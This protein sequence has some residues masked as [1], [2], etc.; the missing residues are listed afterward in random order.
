[1]HDDLRLPRKQTGPHIL[2]YDIETAYALAGVWAQW[3]TNATHIERDWYILCFAYKWL[4]EGTHWVGLPD[5]D[6]YSP[7]AHDDRYVVERLRDLLDYADIVI[8]HNGDSFDQ[9]KTNAR[10]LYHD[11]EI[12]TPYQSIDTKKIAKKYFNNMSNSLNELGRIY[13]QQEKV[14]HSGIQLWRDCIAGDPKAWRE[15]KKYNLQ[16]VNI[17]EAVYLKMRPWIER[18]PNRGHWSTNPETCP[19]C[20][21]SGQMIRRGYRYTPAFRYPSFQ[22]KACGGYSRSP[23]AERYTR[24]ELR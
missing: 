3:N 21:V 6:S 24:T 20:G 17:L 16:D 5:S 18:H 8:A 22:C 11:L 13:T 1:M 10:I 4:G 7:D 9:K 2:L 12:P 19:K 23:N 15:M 14:K